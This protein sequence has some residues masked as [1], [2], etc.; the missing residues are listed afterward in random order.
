ML[1]VFMNKQTIFLFLCFFGLISGNNAQG[2]SKE[3]EMLSFL[4]SFSTKPASF[5]ILTSA[6]QSD[7]LL[8]NREIIAE[9]TSR[10]LL[11]YFT[12]GHFI[13]PGDGRIIPQPLYLKMDAPPDIREQIFS[14]LLSEGVRI[15]SSASSSVHMLEIEW[16]PEN[17][18]VEKRDGAFKRI[19]QASLHF[20]WADEQGE[21]QKV[22]QASFSREDILPAA[23]GDLTADSWFPASIQHHQPRQ[24]SR[25]VHRLAEP[26]LVTGAVVLTLYLLYNVRS[27]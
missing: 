2:F 15:S 4:R 10:K 20:T 12:D 9:E 24:R 1:P 5:T 13:S 11:A 21:I 17:R 25:I 8:S 22:W 3:G 18:L 16:S 14:T 27:N 26:L 7:T 23:T 6:T 19:M